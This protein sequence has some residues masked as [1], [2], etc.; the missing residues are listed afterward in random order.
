[1]I[2]THRSFTLKMAS[3]STITSICDKKHLHNF[4]PNGRSKTQ[5]RS[6]V[7]LYTHGSIAPLPNDMCWTSK[8][9]YI[10]CT[11]G[12]KTIMV[13]FNHCTAVR[14]IVGQLQHSTKQ[15]E[16]DRT[17]IILL[18]V[19][20]FLSVPNLNEGDQDMRLEH[21]GFQTNVPCHC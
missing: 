9:N 3:G 18:L 8:S 12:N 14:E 7:F 20:L 19:V 1:M 16:P 2:N 11:S 4:P 6:V 17:R 13:S 15:Y 10:G 5:K 21:S